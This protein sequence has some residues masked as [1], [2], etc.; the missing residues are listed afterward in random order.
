MTAA[1]VPVLS[2]FSVVFLIISMANWNFLSKPLLCFICKNL[3][4][5]VSH[6]A[7]HFV[8]AILV[9]PLTSNNAVTKHMGMMEM[10]SACKFYLF[11]V[12]HLQSAQ[13][14]TSL[15]SFVWKITTLFV[16]VVFSEEEI[17]WQWSF[18]KRV[19]LF[20]CVL[21]SC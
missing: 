20:N 8:S 2:K 16:T 9:L 17:E 3:C 12:I 7:R 10:A 21:H 4:T 13:L 18:S 6:H 1:S 19:S 14:S 11:F 15:I 5:T